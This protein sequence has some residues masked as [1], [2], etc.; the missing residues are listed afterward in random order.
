MPAANATGWHLL[1]CV[2]QRY[3]FDSPSCGASGGQQLATALE[4]LLAARGLALP[5]EAIHCFGYC[6]EG[7]NVRLAPGGRFFHRVTIETLPA[8]VDSVVAE[9]AAAHA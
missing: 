7:A 6:T 5:V 9:L 2:N 8:L 1:V 3:G 4:R